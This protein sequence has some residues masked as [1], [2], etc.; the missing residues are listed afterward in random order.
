MRLRH[1]HTGVQILVPQDKA[2]RL[3]AQGDY[4]AVPDAEQPPHGVGER[5]PPTVPAKGATTSIHAAIARA[6]PDHGL[7]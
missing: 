2:T 1:K 4:L 5:K 3:I 6:V 7:A